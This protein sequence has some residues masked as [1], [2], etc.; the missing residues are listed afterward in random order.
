VCYG[1]VCDELYCRS[2]DLMI[3]RFVSWLCHAQ[4]LINCDWWMNKAV[5]LWR[6]WLR[7]ATCLVNQAPRTEDISSDGVLLFYILL[8]LWY[9]NILCLE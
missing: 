6:S 7:F 4:I 2:I 1:F 9:G 3:S 5:C 8:F